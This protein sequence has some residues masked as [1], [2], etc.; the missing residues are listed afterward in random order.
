MVLPVPWVD[1]VA[2][3]AENVA[4]QTTWQWPVRGLNWMAMFSR[5]DWIELIGASQTCDERSAVTRCRSQRR[6]NNDEAKRAARAEMFVHMGELSS[7]R[8]ALVG[9][10]VAP[11][12]QA[13]YNQLT[14]ATRRPP[15]GPPF[16]PKSAN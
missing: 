8:Q 13:T 9:E 14:D 12:N 7:A 11:G 15:F 6:A 16:W 4:P 2:D 1:V 10:A 3:V 5:E